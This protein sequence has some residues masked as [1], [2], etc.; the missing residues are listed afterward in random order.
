MECPFEKSMEITADF[1]NLTE[2]GIGMQETQSS[3]KS[4]K[5][6]K[7]FFPLTPGKQSG[8]CFDILQNSLLLLSRMLD[9]NPP[10]LNLTLL[11]KSL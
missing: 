2:R 4:Q 6:K 3:S 11:R 8:A 1:W 10:F 7:A 5:V 9:T